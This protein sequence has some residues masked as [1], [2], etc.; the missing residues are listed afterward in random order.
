MIAQ[1]QSGS[2]KTATF[3]LVMLYRCDPTLQKIQALCLA[4]TR[5]LAIQI[6]SVVKKMAKLTNIQTFLCV[7]GRYPETGKKQIDAHIVVGTPGRVEDFVKR[8]YI[9]T[10]NIR[11]F[12]LDEAD[13]MV[14]DGM[15]DRSMF[16]KK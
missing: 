7:P 11:V 3:S 10:S 4:P 12:V 2:G 8:R 14:S 1:A 16:I 6:E 15:R 5:E 9:D 13:V